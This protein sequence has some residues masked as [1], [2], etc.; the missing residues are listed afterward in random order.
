M[1]A[2]LFR[3]YLLLSDYNIFDSNDYAL[4]L[5]LLLK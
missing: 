3:L 5:A 1:T 4:I 2:M